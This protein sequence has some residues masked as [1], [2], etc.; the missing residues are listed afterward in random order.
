YSEA[1]KIDRE[2][3]L[4]MHIADYILNNNDRHEQNWGFLMENE[5]GKL[6]GFCPLFDHDHTF[7]NYD[8]VMSQITESEMTLREPAIRA[9]KELGLKADGLDG[10][11]RPEFLSEVQCIDVQERAKHLI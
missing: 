5:T 7:V 3:Y 10:I 6:T 1:E 2:F 4:K 8:N 9:A 11:D